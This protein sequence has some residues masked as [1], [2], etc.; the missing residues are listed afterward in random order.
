MSC[1]VF[2]KTEMMFVSIHYKI[3]KKMHLQKRS[4]IE[5]KYYDKRPISRSLHYD[6]YIKDSKKVP[7]TN[8][9]R[10]FNIIFATILFQ[11]SIVSPGE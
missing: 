1:R 7:I 9:S 8:V 3:V 11:H 4:S 2:E 6:I 5:T 10:N